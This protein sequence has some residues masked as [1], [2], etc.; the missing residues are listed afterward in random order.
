[1]KPNAVDEYLANVSE[2][3][4][5][6]LAKVRATIRAA[7]PAEAVEVISYGIPAFKY[8]GYLVGFAAFKNHCSLFAMNGTAVG[9][10]AEELKNYRTSKGTIQ[11]PLDK[12]LPKTLIKKLVKARI[13]KNEA[14]AQK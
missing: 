4:R 3:A 13:A 11:F 7:A 14:A 1:M 10:L 6:T 8:K 2:P 12:P 5:T 9:E